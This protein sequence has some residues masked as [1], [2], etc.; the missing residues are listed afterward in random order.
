M[1]LERIHAFMFHLASV[2]GEAVTGLVRV[3][4]SHQENENLFTITLP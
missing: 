2:V 4:A 1:G 3:D